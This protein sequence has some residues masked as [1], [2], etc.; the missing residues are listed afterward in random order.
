M[1]RQCEILTDAIRAGIMEAFGYKT[2][3]MEFVESEHTPKNILIIGRK[4]HS[5]SQN[6][7]DH[8]MKIVGDAQEIGADKHHLI[9]ILNDYF[10]FY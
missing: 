2:N 7:K 4:S 6:P 1:D 8:L 3:V 5:L 9:R 10:D